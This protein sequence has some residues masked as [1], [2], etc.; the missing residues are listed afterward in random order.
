M[1]SNISILQH[2][3]IGL[4]KELISIPSLSKQEDQ[5]AGLL[6]RFLGE[7]DIIHTRVGNNVFALNKHFDEKKPT[8]L[9]NSHH[10]TVKPNPQYSRDPYKPDV[11]EN[12]LFGLGSNDAGG[13]L[14]SLIATYLHFYDQQNLEYNIIIAATAEEE[15]SGTG[16]IEYTI[17]YLPPIN[18]AIV[19]EPTQ[20]QMAVAERGLLV[21]DCISHGKAGHAA[22][23]EGENAIYNAIEDIN[24]FKTFHFDKVSDL[25]GPVKMSVTSIETEN[26]A[27]NVIPAICGF[28]VD[29]RVNE[30]YSFEEILSVIQANVK[31]E[32]KPRSTRLRSTSI[33]LDHPLVKAGIELGKTYYGSPTTSDK[34]LMTFPSL[35]IGPGDSARSHTAD[36]FIYLNEIKEG[37]ESYIQLL[38]LVV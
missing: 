11:E 37:I 33:A 22:R 32:I 19:G 14:V 10:D 26:K 29:T 2:E 3:A 25:L 6:C 16:G 27:H 15:I 23:D 1:N 30:L 9:L 38:N 13:C 34:A 24:W 28:V 36:E 12:K 21:L 20:M 17:P 4:L 7:K 18:C 5:T 35:K 31:S 8:I